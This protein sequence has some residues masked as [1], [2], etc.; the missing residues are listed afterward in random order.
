MKLGNRIRELRARD[1]MTQEKLADKVN[2]SRQTI[3]SIEKGEY[4]PSTLLSLKIARV[5]GVPF[6]EI[7]YIIDEE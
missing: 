5:F 1:K 7:F 4:T 3:I 6:E 2:V